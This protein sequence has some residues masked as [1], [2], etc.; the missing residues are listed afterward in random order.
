MMILLGQ[1]D[2]CVL[3]SLP[4]CNLADLDLGFRLK[5]SRACICREFPRKASTSHPRFNF[6]HRFYSVPMS[7]RITS[8][9]LLG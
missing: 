7:S 3:V 6:G 2:K 5:F 4:L 9:T 1:I 8:S